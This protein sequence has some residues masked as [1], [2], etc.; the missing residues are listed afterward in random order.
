MRRAAGRI[1]GTLSGIP[2]PQNR[3]NP[4]IEVRSE[5]HVNR[6]RNPELGTVPLVGVA[7]NVGFELHLRSEDPA[8]Q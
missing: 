7:P 2:Q 1:A 5:G 3:K 8:N 4:K 6:T